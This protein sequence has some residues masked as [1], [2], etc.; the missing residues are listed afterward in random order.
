MDSDNQYF[1]TLATK[2]CAE[3][4]QTKITDYYKFLNLNGYIRLWANNYRYFFGGK[5]T[6]GQVNAGGTE[7]EYRVLN[8]NHF[9]N[10]LS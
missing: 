5:T 6:L 4:L 3:E 2:E 1:A 7:G 8:V 10:L 9:R